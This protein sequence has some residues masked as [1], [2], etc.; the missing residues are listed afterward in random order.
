MAKR[1]RVNTAHDPSSLHPV[2]V[3][4]RLGR[5]GMLIRASRTVYHPGDTYPLHSHDYAE[6]SWVSR[7]RIFLTDT[8]GE[9]ELQVGD[10]C[11]IHPAY[12]HGF[13]L[14]A[15][16]SCEL[17]NVAVPTATIAD[18]SQRYAT[19][20]WGT[21]TAALQHR[22]SASDLAALDLWPERLD[23]CEEDALQRDA[24]LLAIQA[25]VAR[26]P[27]PDVDMPEW[28]RDALLNFE[29]PPHLAGG[30]AALVHLTGRSREHCSR[31]VRS[32]LDM[33][34]RDLVN[35]RRLEVLS[36]RLREDQRPVREL[37]AEVWEAA[38]AQLYRL[39]KERYG[40]TPGEWRRQHRRS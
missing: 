3:W 40:C 22:L 24:C 28:L 2:S 9:H 23:G 27:A 8:D 32:C 15:D 19:W 4:A 20:R 21:E 37:V 1:R 26:A 30:A 14:A 13:R 16:A 6:C 35:Q 10:C 11:L 38:P 25:A 5:P 29:H 33:T 34:L 18:L 12:R 7:G 39:F 36:R 17:V 31:V